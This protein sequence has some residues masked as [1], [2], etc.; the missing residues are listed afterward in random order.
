C[1]LGAINSGE[2][3]WQPTAHQSGISP[4]T[5]EIV[6]DPNSPEV[7]PNIRAT[8]QQDRPEEASPGGSAQE[9]VALPKRRCCS[10]CSSTF[11]WKESLSRHRKECHRKAEHFCTVSECNKRFTRKESVSRHIKR[12]HSGRAQEPE[13]E[14]EALGCEAYHETTRPR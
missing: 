3:F 4:N 5:D 6:G 9:A 1:I 13:T 7:P 11:G 12:K 14:L 8:V 2:E 10:E